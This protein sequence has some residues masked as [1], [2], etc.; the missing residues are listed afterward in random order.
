MPKVDRS[1]PLLR[2]VGL[3]IDFNHAVCLLK[4]LYIIN[5]IKH[6][7]VFSKIEFS[8]RFNIKAI[9]QQLV[10]GNFADSRIDYSRENFVVAACEGLMNLELDTA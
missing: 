5:A 10:F 1:L 3:S 8:H 6:R 4:V 9:D 7:P 2:Q